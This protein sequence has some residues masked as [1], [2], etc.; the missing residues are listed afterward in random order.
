[1]TIGKKERVRVRISKGTKIDLKEE[2]KEI[3]KVQIEEIKV[4]TFMKVRLEGDN[5]DIKALSHAEQIV[6]EEEIT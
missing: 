6:F 1:M 2:L 3:E 4:G 5:F